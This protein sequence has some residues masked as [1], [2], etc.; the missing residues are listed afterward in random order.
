[1]TFSQLAAPGSP[2]PRASYGGPAEEWVGRVIQRGGQ[3][4]KLEK[5]SDRLTTRL[6]QPSDLA[7][8]QEYLSPLAVRAVAAGQLVEWQVQPTALEATLEKARRH[9]GVRFAS[10]VYYLSASPHSW[11]YL[12]AE[13]TVQFA[14]ATPEPYIEAL[15]QALGLAIV[16]PLK[17]IPAA[18]VTEVTA[19]AQ[20]N[21]IKLANRLICDPA[22]LVAE[23]NL[24][25]AVDNFYH[26]RD[27]LYSQQWH[28]FHQG[29]P[30][31]APGSHMNVEAAWDITRGSRSV[32]IAITD[33]GFDLNHP[34][35]Q[36]MGKLVNP[37][38]LQDQDAVPLPSHQDDSHGT[39]VAGLALGE[40]NGTGIVGVAPG[41]ALLPI[42]T[43]GFLDDATIEQLFDQAVQRGAA[44]ISC[45]WSAAA[46]AF[47][48]TLRQ[49]N[50]IARA[51]REG[52]NGKGCVIVFAAGNAN[53]PVSGTI[54][55]A[56]WPQNALSGPTE[57]LSGFAIHPDV[58]AVSACTS[59]ATKAAYSNWGDHVAVTAPSNNAPPSMALPQ[60]G[61]VDTG[62]VIT[63]F[64]P[65]LGMVTSDRGGVEGYG[66]GS[67]TTDFGGT[68]SSC[69]L[70]AGVAALM[71]SVN[72]TLTAAQVRQILQT[73]AD[74]IV[75]PNPDPQ[76]GL[77]YGTYDGRGHSPWFGYGKVNAFA[78]VRE[79]QQLAVRG[80]SLRQA[81]TYQCQ[82]PL[83]IPDYP[84]QAAISPLTV[85][86]TGAVVDLQTQVS[87][88]HQFLGDLSLTLVAPNGTGVVIQTRILGRQRQLRQVYSLKTTPALI[89]M[90]GLEAR[91]SWCLQVRDHAPGA[92][93]QL[94]SWQLRLGLG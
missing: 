75:D 32:V 66:P 89:A 74:K 20:E 13:I 23:P 79:A 51:A 62:P 44:V 81:V 54:Q 49:T 92:T 47:A 15:L 86:E 67:Y 10:H 46:N 33:D 3:E 53:R 52:R 40:E 48:L 30:N 56:H 84:A 38:D 1:M 85:T 31:L 87:V 78:A 8:L 37:I 63:Q 65:G 24:V 4:L 68:S 57:W 6:R 60:V 73:T 36:G 39:A 50:A 16:Q 71:L 41:C 11:I 61:T 91:G 82:T 27:D 12:T 26:P 59:L 77:R 76:L 14:A 64:L 17:G 29:G 19:T 5:L 21:P 72:P 93:G 25:M 43:T 35:L 28:L 80:R 7:A 70:V 69:P 9:A 18:F 42:R 90:L 22:V 94:L 83:T 34:D 2:D 88:D 45:S 58:I 55:E